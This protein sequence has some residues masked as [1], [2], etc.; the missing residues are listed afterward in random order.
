MFGGDTAITDKFQAIRS[1]GHFDLAIMPIGSY[2]P[3][4]RSHCTPEE[5]VKMTNDARAEKFLPIHFKTFRLGEE[6]TTEPMERLEESIAP[7]RI[8]LRDIGE[9]F[10]LS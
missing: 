6:G 1:K 4:K 3:F 5:S 7:D 9:T 8:A 2:K 10:R